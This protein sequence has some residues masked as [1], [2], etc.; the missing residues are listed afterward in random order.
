[1][2]V[3]ADS[4]LALAHGVEGRAGLEP[5]DLIVV[6]GL[7]DLELVG[8]SIG[9]LAHH[10]EGLAGLEVCQS[11]DADLV[12]GSDLQQKTAVSS[13]CNW[14]VHH[15]TMLAFPLPSLPNIFAQFT[16]PSPIPPYPGH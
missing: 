12:K 13:T 3:G 11:L 16:T 14:A 9:L 6:E 1:M 7:V 8:G 4:S 2:N 10:L 15:A 5:G